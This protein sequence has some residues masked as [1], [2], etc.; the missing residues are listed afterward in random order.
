MTVKETN[1]NGLSFYFEFDAYEPDGWCVRTWGDGGIYDRKIQ[2]DKVRH[3]TVV[4]D[5]RGGRTMYHGNE[6]GLVDLEIN[7]MGVR[8]RYEW[9]PKQYQKTAQIKGEVDGVGD[10]T[11]WEYDD[12]GNLIV[13]RDALGNETRW[14]YDPRGN[15]T[16]RTDAAGGVWRQERDDR[17][18][19][20]RATNPLGEVTRYQHD[21][22]GNLV[23]VEDPKGRRTTFLYTPSGEL[24]EVI[25]PEGAPTKMEL[26]PRGLPIAHVDPLGGE[27]RIHRDAC[28]RAVKVERPDGLVLQMA[29]DAEGNLVEYVDALG[30]VTRLRYGG[31]NKLIERTDPIGGVVR[32]ERDTE[33]D[34]VGVVNEAGERYELKR[35]LAGRV[36]E[37]RG[38]DGRLLQRTYDRRGRVDETV[39]AHE[40]R[41]R[42]EHDAL[43]RVVRQIV[44]RKPV[45]GDPLPKGEPCDYGYDALGHLVHAKNDACEVT[46]VR[47]ALSRVV[48]ERSMAPGDAAP[49]V[50]ASRFDAA[51]DRVGRRTSLG[52]EAGYDFDRNGDL[53]GV[54]FGATA[55]F[56]A[57]EAEALTS[58]ATVRAPWKAAVTR[59][60]LG[61]EV[62]RRL[63]GG[64]VSRW[65]RRAMGRPE[66]QEVALAGAPPA[67][68]GYRWRSAE[69]LA[70]LIDTQEGPTW[71]EHDARGHLVSAKR[72]D[73][74]V[75]HRAPDAVGNVYRSADRSDRA[76]AKGGGL[77]E[78]HGV[79]YVRDPD[80]QLV[81]RVLPDGRTWKYA[82]DL[83]GQLVAVTRPDGQV[84]ELGYDAL[85]RRVSKTFA[86][87]T[88]RFV[89]DGNDLVHEVRSEAPP[90]TWV[91]EP[92]TFAPLA[93][94]EGGER[95]AVVTDHLGAPRMLANE[96][97]ELAWKAQLDV[98][99]VARPDVMET[100]CPWRWPGQYEDEETGLFY[101]RF[102]YYDPVSGRYISQDPIRLRGGLGLFQYVTDPLVGIDP[103]GLAGLGGALGPI[104]K[105]LARIT[106]QTVCGQTADHQEAAVRGTY[107]HWA[108]EMETFV[109][110]FGRET[111]GM[112]EKQIAAMLR[113]QKV[114]E[115]M[116]REL[117]AARRRANQVLTEKE[118]EKLIGPFLPGAG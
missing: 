44:P 96:A 10:R 16:V 94:E 81:E 85:G 39:D 26:D 57:F 72:P 102:R 112:S 25:G 30:N 53:V 52:H 4:D 77:E 97:G 76:Y 105:H 58:G 68:L 115:E 110:N 1:R 35:D 107:E 7:P 116:L 32:L 88:T 23:T 63:P 62:E 113:K 99:G 71:F 43:G 117:E 82:W 34:I 98:Y 20:V 13:E 18:M 19:V 75:Q 90:V 55:S 103:L 80:G 24:N 106:G 95:F 74:S 69:Q 101:N 12:R 45:L 78:V 38:F 111:A 31:L 3:L 56:G 15:A 40:K 83:A 89:W 61:N 73:G 92:D 28:G 65:D 48:E 33:E 49:V 70:G 67:M 11:E 29:H 64:V 6:G 42:F 59:D 108:G 87:K 27:T 84:V 41:T 104:A 100:A 60:A 66:A 22:R 8:T 5:S 21:R 50:V 9:H 109:K 86:G 118:I 91:F 93:K 47:D 46:F 54:T 14:T 114:T 17:G 79:R 36:V 51:G 2:Y 37:E